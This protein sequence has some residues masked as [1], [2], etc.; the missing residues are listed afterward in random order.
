MPKVIEKGKREQLKQN[1]LRLLSVNGRMSIGNIAKNLHVTK[2][3]AYHLFLEVVK[4]YDLHFVPEINIEELWKY[5]FIKLNRLHSKREMLEESTEMLPDLGFDEY[6]ILVKFPEKEPDIEKTARELNASY[7]VQF[8]AKLKGEYDLVI[9]AL[10][11]NYREI[12]VT[13]INFSLKFPKNKMVIEINKID[14]GM[15]FFALKDDLIKRFNI[16]DTYRA[17]LLGLNKNGRTEFKK[18]AEEFNKEPQSIVYAMD[19]L[20][21]TDILKRVTYYE[22][23]PKNVINAVMYVKVLNNSEL[24]STRSK[25]YMELVNNSEGKHNVNMFVCNISSPMSGLFFLSLENGEALESYVKKSKK[26]MKG[27]DIK[28][29]ILTK[30]LLG[31]IGIRNFDMRYSGFYKQLEIEKFVPK[32]KPKED[33]T[34]VDDEEESGGAGNVDPD[35]LIE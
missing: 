8:A 21:R 4:E 1:M 10:A 15:G 32:F 3:S 12:E 16:S 20:K 11:R 25:W 17:L 9:Y 34:V 33:S 13:M 18:I 35:I 19:R 22:G 23:N 5:E 29:S 28:Y 27:V 2:P 7:M 30:V 31:N 26:M 6:I 14:H 24:H